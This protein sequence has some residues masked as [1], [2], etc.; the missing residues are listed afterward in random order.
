MSAGLIFM[1]LTGVNAEFRSILETE[2]NPFE[3]QGGW[4]EAIAYLPE[5]NEDRWYF[6]KDMQ[7]KTRVMPP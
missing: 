5:E 2:E 4:R 7:H 1:R 6:L 3:P